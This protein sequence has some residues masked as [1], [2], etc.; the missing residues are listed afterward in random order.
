MDEKAEMSEEDR[1]KILEENPQF[2]P[3]PDTGA[4]PLPDCGPDLAARF[5]PLKKKVRFTLPI[6]SIIKGLTEDELVEFVKAIDQ[7]AASWD[8][9]LELYDYFAEQKHIHLKEYPEDAAARGDT[10]ETSP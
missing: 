6:L 3:Q 4:L 2:A 8:L 7:E 9:S 1:S 5:N 10:E